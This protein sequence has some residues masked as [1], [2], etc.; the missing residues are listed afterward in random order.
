M[1]FLLDWKRDWI[2]NKPEEG[3]EQRIQ[4]YKLNATP[5]DIC[6]GA[7]TKIFTSLLK[8]SYSYEFEEQPRYEH[9]IGFFEKTLRSLNNQND[10]IFSWNKKFF[11]SF[12]DI[13]SEE[14]APTV[15][16]NGLMANP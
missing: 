6:N 4:A 13:L 15:Q 5:E 14:S 1:I 10:G 11:K 12:K 2:V 3:E 7:K 16:P 9:F 8:E